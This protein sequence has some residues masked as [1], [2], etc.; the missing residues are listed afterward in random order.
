MSNSEEL[1][2]FIAK[3]DEV[4]AELDAALAAL[5]AA[6]EALAKLQADALTA[7]R[8]YNAIA[9]RVLAAQR[10]EGS[11]APALVRLLDEA[12]RQK[13]EVDGDA[14]LARQQLA[15]L[16]WK[17]ECLRADLEQLDRVINPPPPAGR[18]P[19][20]VRR[21]SPEPTHVEVIE[22][23]NRPGEAA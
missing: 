16:E 14:S 22:F 2:I 12:R 18:L 23:R 8:R 10:L 1:A 4:S 15:N 7:G 6:R 21:V 3:R 9:G 17:I 13:D 19:E 20:V 11:T 5:P